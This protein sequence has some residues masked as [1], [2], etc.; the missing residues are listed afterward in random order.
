MNVNLPANIK[1]VSPDELMALT[2]QDVPMGGLNMPSLRINY[3][4]EDDDGNQLPRGQWTMSVDGTQVF[5]PTVNVRILFATHQYGHYDTDKNKQV[6]TSVHF[7][8][9]SDDIID[10]AGGFRCGKVSRDRLDT[11]SEAEQAVQKDIKLSRV[12]FCLVDIVGVDKA[13]EPVEGKAVPAVF[14]A[15]GT[16]FMP[17]TD[18]LKML[19]RNKKLMQKVVTKFDIQR[20][21]NGT[22]TYFEVVPSED[23][24]VDS[25][26]KEDMELLA[27]AVDAV[28]LENDRVTKKWEKVNG[29]KAEKIEES[30]D[31]LTKIMDGD[32]DLNDELPANLGG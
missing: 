13:G 9:W 23:G 30:K 21:K 24:E 18:Y 16:N 11:L 25:I 6:S 4:E 5:A 31:L 15:K 12:L 10:D 7:Q 14:Y 22:L 17:M 26:T 28:K 19:T 3:H 20:K 8:N 27:D 29:G 2:G 1:D 32:D